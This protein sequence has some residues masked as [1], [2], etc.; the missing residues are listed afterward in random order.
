METDWK[1]SIK[2]MICTKCF[3]QISFQYEQEGIIKEERKVL[4]N[5]KNWMS[6]RWIRRIPPSLDD[7]PATEI[8]LMAR[9]WHQWR[10]MRQYTVSLQL[11]RMGMR[12]ASIDARCC[13][14]FRA[15]HLTRGAKRTKA[16]HARDWPRPAVKRTP[17]TRTREK[18]WRG[19][20]RD[21]DVEARLIL[22]FVE[23]LRISSVEFATVY[24][25][26]SRDQI[27]GI[28]KKSDTEKLRE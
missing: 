12:E 21:H 7:Y 19:Y 17:V 27:S 28:M 3:V 25:P 13:S 8:F 1:W 2:I 16:E 18:L 4:Y 11:Q 15:T 22:N 10:Q 23:T 6:C 14:S 26:I 20:L 5:R 24:L 9:R